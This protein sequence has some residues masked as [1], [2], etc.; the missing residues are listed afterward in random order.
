MFPWASS[1]IALGDSSSVQVG[2]PFRP[3][4]ALRLIGLG[5][6]VDVVVRLERAARPPGDGADK[7]MRAEISRAVDAS[8]SLRNKRDLVEDFVEQVSPKGDVDEEWQAFIAARRTL[9]LDAII[10]DE[11]LKPEE[12]KVFVQSA[13]RDGAVPTSGTAVTKIL[14]PVSRF[15]RDG[16]RGAKKQRVLARLGAFFE[17]F[18]S[19]RVRCNEIGIMVFR[20]QTIEKIMADRNSQAVTENRQPYIFLVH[21]FF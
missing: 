10:T 12:T 14:P 18:F 2:D 19:F 11:G 4:A 20:E 7:E 8:P 3:G 21:E 16:G 1:A 5:Q 9:E 15:S 13:F 17:R 6:P